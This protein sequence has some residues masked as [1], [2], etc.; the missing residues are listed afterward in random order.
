MAARLLQGAA[1]D[2][3]QHERERPVGAVVRFG[4]FADG[5]EHLALHRLGRC[6]F[7]GGSGLLGQLGARCRRLAAGWRLE[8]G[9][10]RQLGDK[11]AGYRVAG[12]YVKLVL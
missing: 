2:Q 3:Q 4:F 10:A 8:A 1:T 11:G 7:A 6:R 9:A 12:C 5:F